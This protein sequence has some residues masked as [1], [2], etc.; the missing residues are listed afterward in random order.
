MMTKIPL[1][2]WSSLEHLFLFEATFELVG[3]DSQLNIHFTLIM[4]HLL[5]MLDKTKTVSLKESLKYFTQ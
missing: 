3:D 2:G 1:D 5:G 4:H